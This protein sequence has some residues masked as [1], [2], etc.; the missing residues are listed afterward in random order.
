M[1]PGEWVGLIAGILA[2]LVAIWRLIRALYH[3]ARL[4]EKALERLTAVEK[5][6]R[7][8]SGT[9]LRD[10]V[11]QVHRIAQSNEQSNARLEQLARDAVITAGRAAMTAETAKQGLDEFRTEQREN[12]RQNLA[13][14][15]ALEETDQAAAV[16][17]EFLL[18]VLKHDYEIDLLPDEDATDEE[19]DEDATDEEP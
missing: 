10:R 19:P 4:A 2:I 17:R 1:G 18:G 13:R 5:E 11:D 9:S 7:P 12:H 8:N 3:L 14:F 16:S 15:T 6:L